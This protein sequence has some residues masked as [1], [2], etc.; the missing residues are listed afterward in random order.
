MRKG[1]LPLAC[2]SPRSIWGTSMHKGLDPNRIKGG[3]ITL[4]GQT[5][6]HSKNTS[7]YNAY[8]YAY[9]YDAAA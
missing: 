2:G 3:G 6:L 7:G 4:F 9:A 5:F 1:A 8:A